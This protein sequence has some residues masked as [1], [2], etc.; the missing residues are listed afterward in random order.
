M[1]GGV[2]RLLLLSSLIAAASAQAE[3]VSLAISPAA[4]VKGRDRS[5]QL[6]IR[7]DGER[8][9]PPVLR[10]NVGSIDEVTRV[11][12][13]RY[14]ARYVLPATRFPEVAIIVA[15]APWPHPQSAEGA[16]G[17]LRVPIASAV[18]IPG[19]AERGAQVTITLAG[20][21]FG[22]ATAT[23][24]GSFKLPV[25][26]PPG[27]GLAQTTTRDRVGNKRV[28][29]VDLA[30]PP[31]DQL[32]CVVT[33]TH[34]P[35][36]GVSKARVLCATSDRYGAPAKAAKVSWKSGRGTLSA[37]RELGNGVQEWTWTAPL[38]PGVGFERLNATWKQGVVDSA[39]EVTVGLAQGAVQRLTV[40]EFDDV[41]H[42]GGVW[43]SWVQAFDAQ[44][45]PLAGVR[46]EGAEALTDARGEAQVRWA[47]PSETPLGP[48][49]MVL[50]GSGPA[51]TEPASVRVFASDAG[52]GV[53]VG[54]LA[55]LPVANQRVIGGAR[56]VTTDVNGE[57]IF[58]GAPVPS[59]VHHADW[60][61]L[62]VVLDGGLASRPL[63]VVSQPV[64]V[65]PPLP[66][67]VRVA[68]GAAGWSWWVE[69]PSGEVLD[70][71]EVEVRAG[72]TAQRLVSRGRLPLEVRGELVTVTDLQTRV[73]ALVPAGAR[74]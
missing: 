63:V 54:D 24:D 55:G 67:N 11:G 17:V 62:S 15:F 23:E 36:D 19:R 72:S 18:E 49:T 1:R 48:R 43:A 42:Q 47:V 61:G 71:R 5:A 27:F 37:P 69:S 25:V 30:L 51:G 12:P 35:A 44:G 13:G 41:A 6:D 32:A 39:E 3:S 10:A 20:T 2:R 16:F 21:T 56:T 7:L 40:R 29:N 9:A 65:G 38:D 33:P 45:R 70:G 57:A 52:L 34:L 73:S 28:T 31:T 8:P 46:L 26:V 4:P 60:P 64:T 22:P 58:E 14:T 68:R 53:W 66:V 74:P 59:E 50:E